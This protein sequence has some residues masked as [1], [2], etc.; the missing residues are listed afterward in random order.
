MSAADELARCFINVTIPTGDE[1]ISDPPVSTGLRA[2][3]ELFQS[4]VGLAGASGNFD[5]NGRYLRSTVEGGNLL[6]ETSVVKGL[7]P[8]FGNQILAPLGTRPAFGGKAPPIR[9]DVPCFRNPAPNLNS[10][11]LGGTP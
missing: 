2:Y 1:V 6:V 10:A 3:Q 7:G 5:G 11:K 4:A 9:R 8:L